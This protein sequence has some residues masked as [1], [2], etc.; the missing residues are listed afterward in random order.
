MMVNEAVFPWGDGIG[1]E[2][3]EKDFHDKS[4]LKAETAISCGFFLFQE[5]LCLLLFFSKLVK[6]RIFHRDESLSVSLI[7][8][9]LGGSS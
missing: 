3:P 7:G 8:S 4:G 6:K 2:V 1:G 5:M 9:L